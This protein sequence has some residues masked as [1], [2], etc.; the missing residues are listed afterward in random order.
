MDIARDFIYRNAELR[1]KLSNDLV[2]HRGAVINPIPN[3]I[4]LMGNHKAYAGGKPALSQRLY[5]ASDVCGHGAHTSNELTRASKN[6]VAKIILK[7]HQAIPEAFHESAA[8][9]ALGV[10]FSRTL[11]YRSGNIPALAIVRIGADG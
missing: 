8:D 5:N 3:H 2:A 1:R 6:S 11:G 9:H 4:A 7:A 10:N